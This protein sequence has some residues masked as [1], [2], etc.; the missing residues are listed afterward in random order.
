MCVTIY[1]FIGWCFYVT[2]KMPPAP[3]TLV[4]A[5][6]PQCAVSCTQNVSVKSAVV[7][8]CV[9][10]TQSW[11]TPSEEHRSKRAD[12]WRSRIGCC[13]GS[14]QLHNTGAQSS[15]WSCCRLAHP[16]DYLSFFL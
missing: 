4:G 1:A 8:S 2:T 16:R 11:G 9:G 10:T 5:M 12:T 6:G 14:I 15:E 3:A 7:P 13:C